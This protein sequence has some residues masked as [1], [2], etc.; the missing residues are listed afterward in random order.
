MRVRQ[1][2]FGHAI[3]VYIA[4]PHAAQAFTPLPLMSPLEVAR[5]KGADAGRR[6]LEESKC[7]YDPVGHENLY[8]EWMRGYENASGKADKT[9]RLK[10]RGEP[11]ECEFGSTGEQDPAPSEG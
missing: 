10:D 11:D 8:R 7:P 6:G 2:N 4:L 9:R 3:G 1:P 5:H